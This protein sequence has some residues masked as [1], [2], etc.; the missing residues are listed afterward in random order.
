MEVNEEATCVRRCTKV[1]YFMWKVFTCIFTHIMLVTMVVGYCL[2]GAV[3]FESLEKEYEVF[4]KE[5]VTYMRGNVTEDIWQ[6]TQD[7]D[8]LHQVNWTNKT[9]QRLREFEND[10]VLAIK[11]AG[12]DGDEDTQ[13]LQWTFAGSLFY[14]IIVITTIG[15]G[16]IAPKTYLGKV[17]TIFYAIVGIPL[18]LLCLSNIGDIMATSFRFMYWRVC[19]YT[20][21]REEAQRSASKR[22]RP[23]Y[24]GQQTPYYT[25]RKSLSLTAK[26]VSRYE[27][28]L[29]S[30]GVMP[31]ERAQ[32]AGAV[33]DD[34][35]EVFTNKYA[36]EK[37]EFNNNKEGRNASASTNTTLMMMRK[38]PSTL[39]RDLTVRSASVQGTSSRQTEVAMGNLSVNS[40]G[41]QTSSYRSNTSASQPLSN[42]PMKPVPIWLCVF[43]VVSYIIGGALLF[44]DWEDWG[45]ADS[46]YFCFITLTTIGFG[47]FVPAQRVNRKNGEMSIALC[48][49]YLLFGIALLAMSFNLVQ[50][51]VINNVKKIARSLGI[52]KDVNQNQEDSDYE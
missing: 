20:C 48:S 35:P 1:L 45:Y 31:R 36:I 3:T 11:K 32:S 30:D 26:S 6:L 37:E 51:E 38:A 5:N 39:E 28:S 40:R 41:W 50:E 4:V 12:W 52:L 33:N 23:R 19:C 24:R 47:D 7:M 27:T 14:S 34:R 16:H 17:T 42:P 18:M 25:D 49:L 22:R 21:T 9:T 46:A 44:S 8:V 29:T 10:L 15:Y 43:L 13:V 2:L